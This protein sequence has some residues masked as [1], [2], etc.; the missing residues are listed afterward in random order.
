MSLA[1]TKYFA[2]RTCPVV[3]KAAGPVN[4]GRNTPLGDYSN[5]AACVVIAGQGAGKTIAFGAEAARQGGVYEVVLN[6]LRLDT[7]E[8]Q[9][10]ALFLKGLDESRAGTGD[11]RTPLDDI[12]RKLDRLRF[13]PFRLSCRWRDW[14]AANDREGLREVSPR[15]AVAV[16]AAALARIQD[17]HGPLNWSRDR[18]TF[19]TARK[20]SNAT[21]VELGRAICAQ[22]DVQPAAER[23]TT[24]TGPA[25]R[26]QPT[27]ERERADAR[28][29][30]THPRP[31]GGQP[32][33]PATQ[34]HDRTRDLLAA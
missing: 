34:H 8:W 10:M 6:S 28:L 3:N 21:A 7:P 2:P 18:C 17:G 29:D 1:A 32:R 4:N 30:W 19:D 16:K 11:A 31:I 26:H 9:G 23:K 20:L 22:L 33:K 5:T 27:L 24:V 12:I 15:P 25:K 13:L 14:P